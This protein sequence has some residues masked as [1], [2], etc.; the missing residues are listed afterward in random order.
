VD[1]SQGLR[2]MSCNGFHYPGC[3]DWRPLNQPKD[4]VSTSPQFGPVTGFGT[5]TNLEGVGPVY[6]PPVVTPDVTVPIGDP[7]PV[8]TAEGEAQG[9]LARFGNLVSYATSYG[10]VPGW[11]LSPRGRWA[12][13]LLALGIGYFVWRKSR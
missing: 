4:P 7:V 9:I 8:T 11:Q 1:P 2:I 13:V 12:L 6:V 10:K 3:E 5:G